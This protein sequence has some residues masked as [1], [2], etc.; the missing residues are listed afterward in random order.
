MRV[1]DDDLLRRVI[2]RSPKPDGRPWAVRE[3]GGGCGG[4]V[5][6]RSGRA[7]HL[8][9]A[10]AG[11]AG[12]RSVQARCLAPIQ[13]GGRRAACTCARR[14]K[15]Q[16]CQ[17][18]RTGESGMPVGAVRVS[19]LWGTAVEEQ[20][21]CSRLRSP[22]GRPGD[23][24]RLR[25]GPH[26]RARAAP[27]RRGGAQAQ[28]QQ[29]RHAV[30]AVV[31]QDGALVQHLECG[32]PHR[33][34]QAV[35]CARGS[36]SVSALTAMRPPAQQHMSQLHRGQQAVACA[37]GSPS[38]SALTAMCPPAQQHVSQ[39]NRGQQAVACARGSP[40][41]SALTA[42]CPPAQQHVSQLNRGQQAV[43]CL[44]GSP[45]V[46]ALTAMRRPSISLL[47]AE[48]FGHTPSHAAARVSACFTREP[49]H[50]AARL[51]VCVSHAPC[52]AAA[53]LPPGVH[54][55]APA[56]CLSSETPEHAQLSDTPLTWLSCDSVKAQICMQC[57]WSALSAGLTSLQVARQGVRGPHPLL[58]PAHTSAAR[59]TALHTR[60]AARPR[61]L[62]HV[63]A[64]RLQRAHV[65]VPHRLAALPELL[66]GRGG[67]EGRSA[68]ERHDAVSRLSF[69]NSTCRQ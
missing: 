24:G 33:G 49:S 10:G 53:R 64:R 30:G 59:R 39:L 8:R 35:A 66:Q 12:A 62:R 6:A 7:L 58:Y 52:H 11:P 36:P 4:R 13:W 68:G 40:S 61:Q 60:P 22:G 2:V 28:A 9:D 26:Q 21:R 65:Q 1:D 38:V 31:E 32:Q 16:G 50:A 15:C 46:S 37:R 42:M 3:R 44:R 57:A 41:V 29:R 54:E 67:A 18:S 45:S 19:Q 27:R 20:H 14:H 5:G 47:R 69:Q 56:P 63:V 43:A 51:S 25:A 34:Q 23:D 17:G 48:A 55:A